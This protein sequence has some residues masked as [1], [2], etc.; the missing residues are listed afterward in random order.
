MGVVAFSLVWFPH[1]VL[2]KGTTFVFASPLC[3]VPCSLYVHLTYSY[4]TQVDFLGAVIDKNA[5][6][7]G[8]AFITRGLVGTRKTRAGETKSRS[9]CLKT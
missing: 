6:C 1:F 9:S 2:F 3:K 5:L 4:H 7:T 8:A